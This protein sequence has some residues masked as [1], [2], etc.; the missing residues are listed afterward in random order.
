MIRRPTEDPL[1]WWRQAL[2]DPS[3]PRHDADPQPGFYFRQMVKN[4]PRVPVEVYLHQEIDPDTGD[5]T[6][7]ETVKARQLGWDVDPTVIWTFLKPIPRD[8]FDALVE[9][10]RTDDRMANQ[11]VC[12]DISNQPQRP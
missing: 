10:H 1:K 12:V 3:T 4:G 8:D 5:L 11:R 7:P 9:R 2:R 6:E